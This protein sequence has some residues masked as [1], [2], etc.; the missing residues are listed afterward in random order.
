MEYSIRSINSISEM[1]HIISCY[2]MYSIPSQTL[3]GRGVISSSRTMY[4]YSLLY[5][6]ISW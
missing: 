2:M 5:D 3:S 6:I 1:I 4:L